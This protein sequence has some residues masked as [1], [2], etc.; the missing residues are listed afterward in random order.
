MF[1]VPS[2]TMDALLSKRFPNSD[3]NA[4]NKQELQRVVSKQFVSRLRGMMSISVDMIANIR[5][6]CRRCGWE[7]LGAPD[8][9]QDACEFF[10]FFFLALGGQ[11]PESVRLSEYCLRFWAT[12]CS[13]AS[14]TCYAVRIFTHDAASQPLRL[15]RRTFTGA[16]PDASD[17]GQEEN[18]AILPVPLWDTQSEGVRSRPSLPPRLTLRDGGQTAPAEGFATA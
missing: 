7:Y 10:S 4:G 11:V 16:L 17:R 5:A 1:A 15:T 14:S 8:Q 18:L 9:Q 2:S 13:D 12:D 6:Q 3:M